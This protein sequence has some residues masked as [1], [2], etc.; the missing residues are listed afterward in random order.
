MSTATPLASCRCCG[1]TYDRAAWLRLPLVGHADLEEDGDGR[2]E[3]RNCAD[4]PCRTTLAVDVLVL[5]AGATV[6]EAA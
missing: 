1:A 5:A 6:A 3:M 2:C 4:C